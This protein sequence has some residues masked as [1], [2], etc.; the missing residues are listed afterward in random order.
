MPT[1]AGPTR[2]LLVDDDADLT[3]VLKVRLQMKGYAVDAFND[4]ATALARFVPEKFDIAILDFR[5]QPMNGLEL[6][7]RLRD[8][9]G[10][11]AMCFLTAYANEIEEKPVGVEFLQKPIT[12]ANLIAKLEEIEALV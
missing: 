5:M 8:L 7:H 2:I 12:T 11:L 1:P 9:D 3:E 4:P 6:Y 10:G